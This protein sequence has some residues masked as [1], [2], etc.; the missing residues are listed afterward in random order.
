MS[1]NPHSKRKSQ[2]DT[3]PSQEQIV[4]ERIMVRHPSIWRPPTDVYETEGRL[5]V[6]IEIAGMRDADF[7]IVLQ[8]RNLVVSGVRRQTSASEPT[9]FHRM[10]IPRGEFRATVR[11]PWNVQRDQVSASY[12]DGLLRI[13][14]PQANAQQIRI[15]NVNSETEV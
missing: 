14:L 7:N 6:L 4:W 5:V 12:R 10:E 9:A 1:G 2:P 8:G 11:L 15:I 3:D 13:E